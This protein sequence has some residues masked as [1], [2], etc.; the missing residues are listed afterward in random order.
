M[1]E[2]R[3]STWALILS[4]FV[5][6]IL[7]SSWLQGH[8]TLFARGWL[9]LALGCFVCI[10]QN[11]SFLNTRNAFWLFL[12]AAVL[13]LNHLSGDAYFHGLP[14]IIMEIAT[15]LFTAY[16]V[17]FVIQ[18]H[19]FKFTTLLVLSQLIVI[20]IT[21]VL[22]IQ[23]DIIIPGV[24][25]QTVA[26]INNGESGAIFPFYKMGVCEYGFPHAVPIII[27][28][29]MLMV[30]NKIIKPVIRIFLVL[31]LALLLYLVFVSGVTTALILAI[32]GL[33]ASFFVVEGN[34]KKN[35]RRIVVLGLFLTPLLNDSVTLS[36]LKGFETIVPE[37]NKITG[38]INN[39]EE[40]IQN[41]NADGALQDRTNRY[42]MTFN[43]FLRHPILGVNKTDKLGGHSAFLER[44]AT[45]GIIG[46]IPYIV[47]IVLL[48]KCVIKFIPEKSLFFLYLGFI[49]FIIMLGTKNMSNIYLW[50]YS[51][52]V[53]PSIIIINENPPKIVL[54]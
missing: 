39:F 46:I 41:E 16:L 17:F 27:P 35:I 49:G 48:M 53:L 19:N 31:I 5:P 7:T 38:K 47:F 52:A 25:R 28:G 1:I 34:R 24:I 22:S 4:L 37:E 51:F 9:W 12:Y 26:L 10:S 33:L 30:K 2:K 40:T 29:L 20:V 44:L 15:L 14:S 45:L 6:V 8:V 3:M 43:E 54:R 32:F 13:Y 50:L 11:S 42:M 23:A 21:S 18:K 36:L